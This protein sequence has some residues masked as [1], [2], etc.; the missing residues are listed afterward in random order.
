VRRFTVYNQLDAM[1]CGPACLRMIFRYYGSKVTRETIRT[2]TQLGP[3]GVSLLSLSEAAKIFGFSTFSARLTFDELINDATL[4][5]ILYWDYYHFVVLT[6]QSTEKKLVVADPA[7]GIVTYTKSEFLEHWIVGKNGNEKAGIALL[8]S[9]APEFK[10]RND[11]ERDTG[12]ALLK[13]YTKV[14]RRQLIQISVGLL[15]G[16]LIQ[17]AFPILTQSVVDKGIGPKNLTMIELLIIGQL[18]LLISQ[19]AIEFVRSR[20]LLFISTRISLSVL[21]DFWTKLMK[22]PLHFFDSRQTGDILQRIHDHQRIET[23]VTGVA[24]QTLFSVFSAVAFSAILFTYNPTVFMVFIAG[25]FIYL[26]YIRAFLEKRRKLD[27]NRFT[28]ASKESSMTVQLISGMHE[29]KLNNAEERKKSE[30]RELRA[31]LFDLTFKALTLNQYQQA[32]ALLIN[33]GKNL[34]ITFMVAR[35]VVGE[36]LTIGAMMAIQSIIGMLTSPV[37][38]LVT[39]SQQ[40]QDT[41][42]SLE[43]L[44]EI[45]GLP[46][47]GSG[48]IASVKKTSGEHSI[49]FSD[50]NFAYPGVGNEPVL[51]NINLEFPAG[52]TTAIVGTSGSGK[53]TVLKLIQKFYDGY[54]GKILIGDTD[55]RD[56]DPQYWRSISGSVMQEGFIFSDTIAN[57]ITIGDSTPHQ[58]RLRHACRVAN[59]HMFIDSLPMK[60]DTRIGADGNGISSGQKQRILIARAVYKDPDFIFFDEAT[61]SLDSN[62]EQEIMQNLSGFFRQRTSIIV[63]HRLSTVREADKIIVLEQGRVIEEGDHDRLVSMRGKYFTLVKNQLEL[64]Q[65]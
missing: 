17:L 30:W 59:I 49:T 31:S 28:L 4:P 35:L 63:A 60:F 45:Y 21:T 65:A 36:E 24:L 7:K 48:R 56:L 26:L 2:E 32:G 3:T 8:L 40:A 44:N 46:D 37:E 58:E 43:R 13:R 33:Q 23:F 15:L 11:H 6:P 57:N 52:K 55:L 18:M 10:P 9:P 27:Y 19:T 39:F 42:L 47:E 41:Q 50:L 22:L 62:N 38:R 51:A 5:C 61:N 53:S 1:D 16:S 14:Y 29:I 54:S 25:S 64:D 12:W 34:L 20:T